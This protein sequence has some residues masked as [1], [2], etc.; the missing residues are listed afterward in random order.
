MIRR[1][2]LLALMLVAA[3]VAAAPVS[4]TTLDNGLTVLVKP[5]P[6][7][8][9]VAVEA[10]F[11]ISVADEP[12]NFAGLRGLV[13]QLLLKPIRPAALTELQDRGGSLDGALGLDYTEVYASCAAADFGLA[14]RALAD[15]ITGPDLS[16]D[17]ILAQRR[18][19]MSSRAALDRDAFQAAYLGLREVLHAGHPY[20]R[21]AQGAVEG[22]DAPTRDDLIAFYNHF[23]R[24]ERCVIAI[25]GD[26]DP[27]AAARALRDALGAWNPPNAP[28]PPA[29]PT[30][31][32]GSGPRI[33]LR[34]LPV[35]TASVLI[36]FPAPPA[37][38]PD[39][40]VV[41]VISTLLGGGMSSRLFREIRDTR[42]LA[43]EVNTF[44]PTLVGPSHLGIYLTTDRTLVNEVK[45]V[46]LSEIERLRREPVGEAE[47]ARARAYLIG[48]YQ[49]SRQRNKQQAYY[50][51]WYE[52]IGLG[53]GHDDR[54]PE[55]IAGVTAEQ[56]LDC[57]R[58]HL[59]FPE[60]SLVFPAL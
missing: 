50:L 7:A 14:V 39:Y 47:L 44:Y 36:G 4:R 21:A 31:T 33:R 16:P 37:G 15:V 26:V 9:V 60:I 29:A 27:V 30:E 2:A 24:P 32:A 11:R 59:D 8:S 38:S 52:T 54:Y 12:E 20:A 6:A 42:A 57:A 34:E 13:H 46:V 48:A 55:S 56:V 17:S 35:T 28:A 41:Q 3:P 40:P 19:A 23:Y 58:R 10:F 25:S 1:A 49:L 5:N 51:A 18:A 22:I 53:A 43:Y 45:D